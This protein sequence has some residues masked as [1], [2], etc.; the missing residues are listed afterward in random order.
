MKYLVIWCEDC[1]I[2]FNS[3]KHDSSEQ[4]SGQINLRSKT[5]SQAHLKMLKLRLPSQGYFEN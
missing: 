4:K 2:P 3:E 1:L 5:V